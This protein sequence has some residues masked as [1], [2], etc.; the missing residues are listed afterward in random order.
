MNRTLFVNETAQLL[1]FSA[2]RNQP[3]NEDL[4]RAENI[5]RQHEQSRRDMGL[6]PCNY[7]AAP[8]SQ[9]VMECAD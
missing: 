4:E 3:N 5:T 1:A 9:L 7:I 8:V 6:P 2:N